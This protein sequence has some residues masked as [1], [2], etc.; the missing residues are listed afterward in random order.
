MTTANFKTYTI[1]MFQANPAESLVD[2]I[3]TSLNKNG[4]HVV[5]TLP[6]T[7]TLDKEK[8]LEKAQEII[9]MATAWRH[10]TTT[11]AIMVADHVRDILQKLLA[12]IGVTHVEF[13]IQEVNNGE[14]H[15][16]YKLYK[17]KN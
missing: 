1:K 14:Y 9:N 11:D 16:T 5:S 17:T 10:S 2:F 6:Y 8:L 7:N 12:D 4:N 13:T 3:K 15:A